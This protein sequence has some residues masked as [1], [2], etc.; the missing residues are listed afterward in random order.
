MKISR[1]ERADPAGEH[2]LGPGSAKPG[3]GRGLVSPAAKPINSPNARPVKS[4]PNHRRS[5]GPPGPGRTDGR[6]A[7]FIGPC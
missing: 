1:G 7:L 2:Q 6:R 4:Q 5:R 3:A